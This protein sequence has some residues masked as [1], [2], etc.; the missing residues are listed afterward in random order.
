MKVLDKIKQKIISMGAIFSALILSLG[1]IS[2]PVFAD[3]EPTSNQTTTS[4]QTQAETTNQES[5]TETTNNTEGDSSNTCYDES[6][7]LGWLVCPATGFLARVTDGLYNIIEQYLV[8]KPLTSDSDSPYHQIWSIFRDITNIIFVIFFLIIILSQVTGIG[9]NNYGIKKLLPKIILSAILINLSY[10]I[11]AALVDVSNI[12]GASLKSIFV[13]VEENVTAT[14]LVATAAEGTVIDLSSL[15]SGLI[16]GTLLAGL[17]V[18]ASGG[19]G[20]LFISLIPVLLGAAVAVGVAYLTVALRQ[21]LVYLLIMI[22]PLA[23][24]CNLLPNTEK[25]FGS[26]KKSLTQMLFFYPMFAVLFGACSLVGWVIIA[27]AEDGFSLVLG[28]AVKV[29]PLIASWSLLKM[30]GTLPGQIGA[31]VSKLASHPLGAA[32]NLAG[33]Q[34]A[35]RR[36]KYLGGKPR[37]WQYGRQFGQTIQDRKFRTASDTAKFTEAAKNRGEAYTAN[38]RNK[39]GNVTRR[40]RALQGLIEQNVRAKQAI[41]RSTNDFEKGISSQLDPNSRQYKSILAQDLRNRDA[42]DDLH[43]ETARSEIIARDNAESRH[44]RFE[45]ALTAHSQSALYGRKVDPKALSH[46]NRLK[47]I[48]DG[49]AEATHY[50]GAYAAHAHAVQDKIIDGKFANYFDSIPPTQEVVNRLKDLTNAKRSNQYIDALI[51]GMR[52]LNMRGDTDLVK[53]TIDD[54]LADGQIK[55]G[56]HASQSLANFLMF[57]VKDNDPLLRRYGKF[58]NLETARAF[59]EGVSHRRFNR[60]LTFD[61]YITGRFNEYDPKTGTYSPDTVKRDSVVLLNGTSF[62][63]VER[64]AYANL[65]ASLRKAYTDPNTGVVDIDG[66]TKRRNEIYNAILPA[67]I[68]AALKYPSGSEQIQNQASWLTGYVKK[69]GQWIK[70]WEG[71]KDDPLYGLPESHFRE[72]TEAFVTGQTSNQILNLRTD[73]ILPLI[74]LLGDERIDELSEDEV[75]GRE[76]I[77]LAGERLRD[78]L[79]KKGS[80]ETIYKTRRS[81]AS[82][83]AKWQ[84]RDM[85]K[86]NDDVFVEGYNEKKRAERKN[87]EEEIKEQLRQQGREGDAPT[88]PSPTFANREYFHDVIQELFDEPS[89]EEEFYEDVMAKLKEYDLD[90]IRYK[91]KQYHDQYPTASKEELLQE[92]SDL[93]LSEDNY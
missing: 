33:E 65:D 62:D 81:G 20:A 15:I 14:G 50:A 31:S 90:L 51:T 38:Y 26:W 87:R 92:L 49:D 11:C 71:D 42:V 83:N 53:N 1:V 75:K 45:S 2:T 3:P 64:T 18:G 39:A 21:A 60:V 66:M 32:R 85:L 25:W 63:G 43:T 7:S 17:A 13:D 46:Y 61:E 41:T 69:D 70:R 74:E 5:N 56:T 34:A 47:G 93:I 30:S 77:D 9:I 28:I 8:L 67:F 36:A 48:M 84:I 68:T 22:S 88:Q 16:G 29:V 52:T 24:V 37:S 6:G 72:Q 82:L 27:A 57:D 12:A 58:I 76:K 40:G 19:L 80:L 44:E 73:L 54:I 35:L 10:I 91:F 55:L 89:S 79:D 4:E 78:L 23:F 86:I 59:N